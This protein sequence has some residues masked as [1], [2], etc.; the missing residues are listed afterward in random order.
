M[1]NPFPL[2]SDNKRYHTY[3]YYLT[4][5]FGGKVSRVSLNAG[6]SC[7]NLDGTKGVGGCVY[8]SPTGS[9]E[10]GGDP[11]E[12]IPAQ[13]AQISARMGQKWDTQKHIAYLQARTN[14]YAPVERLR[15]VYEQALG[16]PGVV[17]L[18][19]A[20]RP[21]CLSEPVCDLLAEFSERTYLTVELGLQT[22]NDQTGAALNRCYGL[23]DFL[24]G[25]ARLRARGVSVG[26]HIIDGLPGESHEIMLETARLLAGLELHLVK[27]HLLH[28]IAGTPLA[29]SFATQK[30]PLL[31]REAYVQIACDQLELF[32]PEF[33][34][35]RLTGDGAPDTLIGPD[36]SRKKLCVL[37]EIDKELARRDSWQGKRWKQA[38]PV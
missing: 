22:A 34:I 17:G 26:V 1:K 23:S 20:T 16:C 8:C 27:I 24:E 32:P 3:H 28:V 29:E 36:W 33:V 18:A 15:E 10:F 35:G 2:S 19:V 7:P 21:D 30:F 25:Y 11:R 4:Q 37:N 38:R 14:T 6:M 12:E 13:F 5:R 31:T 9:G